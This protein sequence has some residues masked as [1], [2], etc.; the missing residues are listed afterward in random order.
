MGLVARG[1]GG[2]GG[3]REEGRGV[4]LDLGCLVMESRSL[5]FARRAAVDGLL[6]L[7]F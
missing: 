7:L 1:G 2:A 5:L 6:L 4:G 3:L